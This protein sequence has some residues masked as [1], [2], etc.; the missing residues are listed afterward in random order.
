MYLVAYI[1]IKNAYFI[2]VPSIE[3]RKIMVSLAM[4]IFN[5]QMKIFWYW[6]ASGMVMARLK[7]N[8]VLDVMLHLLLLSKAQ[9]TP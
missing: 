3:D 4:L 9:V 7:I 2:N 5:V 6:H 8:D 1:I